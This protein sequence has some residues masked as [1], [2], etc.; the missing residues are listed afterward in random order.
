MTNL[1]TA[2]INGWESWGKV[3]QSI[4]AFGP[5]IKHIFK[6]HKLPF[7]KVENCTPGTNA[8][9]KVGN[10]IIKIFA[11]KETGLDTDRD[12]ETER[13]GME[14]ANRLGVFVPELIAIGC[15]EHKYFFKYFIME[16]V[17][18]SSLGELEGSLTDR[19]KYRYA[20]QLR[21]I[22]HKLNTP[23]EDFNGIDVL[24]RAKKC[25]S[26]SDFPQ[27]F[28]E[29]RLEYLNNMKISSPVY[30][31]GD[32]NP[33]NVLISEEGKLYIIDFA[34]AVMAPAEYELAALC[35]LFSFEKPYMDGYFNQYDI[36]ELTEKFFN[37]LIIHDFGL[38]IIS[39]KF[40]DIREIDSLNE[41]RKKLYNAIQG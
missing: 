32:L 21:A 9:F 40:G 38:N 23:C 13:F 11:P 3:F 36:S 39:C 35:E 17:S 8:V 24:K 5:L 15:V 14:R 34:D 18:G 37:G 10:Y 12:Y 2:Y 7:T 1:F 27:S 16:Y 22:T 26:W 33:D 19:E 28:Q 41:L 25:Q 4:K 30:V 20:A 31:H 29:Q 6:R